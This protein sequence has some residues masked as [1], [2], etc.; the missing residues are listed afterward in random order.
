[1]ENTA[2]TSSTSSFSYTEQ[3]ARDKNIEEY[4]A[5][6][7]AYTSWSND[8]ILMQHLCYYSTFNELEKDGIE[9][10]VFLEV[11]CGPCPIGR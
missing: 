5:A 6:A 11:G 2:E 8:N 3:E 1:M 7:D 10:K 9:G 4:N